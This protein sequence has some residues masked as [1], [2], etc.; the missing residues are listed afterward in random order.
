MDD[1][2]REHNLIVVENKPHSIQVPHGSNMMFAN[3][4][5]PG[6][7]K[8][9]GLLIKADKQEGA[10]SSDLLPAPNVAHLTATATDLLQSKAEDLPVP[11]ADEAQFSELAVS[12]PANDTFHRQGI[13]EAVIQSTIAT[14]GGPDLSNSGIAS[15]LIDLAS[16]ASTSPPSYPPIPPMNSPSKPLTKVAT[17]AESLEDLEM[18]EEAKEILFEIVN[19]RLGFTPQGFL[20]EEPA[21]AIAELGTIPEEPEPEEKNEV[22]GDAT[23]EAEEDQPEVEKKP[24]KHWFSVTPM[25]LSGAVSGFLLGLLLLQLWEG[26]DLAPVMDGP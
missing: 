13:L 23:G 5:A 8:Q 11:H 14:A 17:Q 25:L 15:P 24:S 20:I 19:A 3:T 12:P 6:D 7:G 26:S 22:L 16:P 1:R 10:V 18:N 9:S 4:V 2:G 21:E